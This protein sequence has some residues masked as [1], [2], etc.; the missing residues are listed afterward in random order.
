MFL[1]SLIRTF[2]PSTMQVRLG[3]GLKMVELLMHKVCFTC[4]DN[5]GAVPCVVLK[6]AIVLRSMAAFLCCSWPSTENLVPL[7]LKNCACRD[8]PVNG[9]N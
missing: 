5:P 4:S 8:K 7:R 6:D 2:L 1:Y 9:S 3:L